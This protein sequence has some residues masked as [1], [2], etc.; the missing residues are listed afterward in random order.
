VQ[1][2]CLAATEACS[3]HQP[4]ERLEAVT[5]ENLEQRLRLPWRQV[6]GILALDRGPLDHGGRVAL[7]QSVPHR[8]VEGGAQHGVDLL[9]PA[10]GMLT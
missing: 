5:M 1:G 10:R 8:H 6:R 2:Q 3:Q 4:V 7:D 9:P